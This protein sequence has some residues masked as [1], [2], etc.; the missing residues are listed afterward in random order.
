MQNKQN[1]TRTLQDMMSPVFTA[2]YTFIST[3][4]HNAS[5]EVIDDENSQHKL[6][7]ENLKNWTN[8]RQQLTSNATR[9]W[10]GKQKAL[11]DYMDE[12]REKRG[13]D[14]EVDLFE[15]QVRFDMRHVHITTS[16]EQGRANEVLHACKHFKARLVN[17]SFTEKYT[18]NTLE[19]VCFVE[20]I[21]PSH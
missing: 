5:S 1:E 6:F 18:E 12:N 20:N 3:T 2:S 11:H 17:N 10:E 4:T 7:Q 21:I 15:V 14:V 16:L 8:W 9:K 13:K 19:K